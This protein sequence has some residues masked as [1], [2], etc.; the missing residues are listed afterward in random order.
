M[1]TNEGTKLRVRLYGIDAPETVKMNRRTG[2]VSKPGQP[3]GEEAYR[4][5]ESKVLRKRVKGQI[6]DVDRYHRMVAILYLGDRDINR[7]MVSEGYAWAYREYLHG[8][9]ASEYIDAEREARSKH[10]GLWQQMNPQPP[11]EFR[12]RLRMR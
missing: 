1:V 7:E 10:L 2:I 11:W 4:V 3:Y 6:M 8:P 9:Y 5:L 12:R